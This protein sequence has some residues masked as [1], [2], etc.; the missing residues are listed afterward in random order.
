M[1]G[2]AFQYGNYMKVIELSRFVDHCQRYSTFG[3]LFF[4][5]QHIT[6]YFCQ[7]FDTRA[8]PYRFFL[9]INFVCLNETCTIL[10]HRSTQLAASRAEIPLLELVG[11][12]NSA[13]S[14]LK[15]LEVIYWI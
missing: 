4:S 1:L 6:L 15:Y 13:D 2:R 11:N 3:N 5:L 14:A 10:T 12:H 8:R 9:V 7:G